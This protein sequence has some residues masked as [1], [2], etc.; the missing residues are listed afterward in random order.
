MGVQEHYVSSARVAANTAWTMT[1]LLTAVGWA[2]ILATPLWEVGMACFGTAGV[3]VVVAGVMQIRIYMVRV[4]ALIRRSTPIS[5]TGS[6][7]R[8]MV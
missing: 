2:V 1:G 3:T 6:N 7:V 4:C 8:S 5:E